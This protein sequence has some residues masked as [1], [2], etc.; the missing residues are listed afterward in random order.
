MHFSGRRS[1]SAP[2][3]A[4]CVKG[5]GWS[6]RVVCAVSRGRADCCS[7]ASSWMPWGVASVGGVQLERPQPVR[8]E[9]A[10]TNELDA[11]QRRRILVGS[12]EASSLR[13]GWDERVGC[14]SPGVL[15]GGVVS[16]A[17]IRH[18]LWGGCHDRDIRGPGCS[19][20]SS[21][22]ALPA[23]AKMRAHPEL[24]DSSRLVCASRSSGT[25]WLW[26]MWWTSSRSRPALR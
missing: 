8:D 1:I 20:R 4:G 9:R 2:M 6:G 19:V 12:E 14:C 18:L 15:V 11:D 3:G 17:P 13:A 21:S 22:A 25:R 16:H 7:G 5:H 23:H 26:W 24:G 10:R